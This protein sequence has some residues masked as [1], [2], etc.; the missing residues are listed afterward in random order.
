MTTKLSVQ[1]RIRLINKVTKEGRSV[2]EVCKKAGISRV[3][4]YRL[5]KRY[6][7]EGTVRPKKN[8]GKRPTRRV[9]E[10]NVIKIISL[11]KKHPRWSSHQLSQHVSTGNH[12][13]WN[14]LAR[15]HLNTVKKR[16]YFSKQSRNLTFGRLRKLARGEI[17]SP[18]PTAL[19][20]KA[21][22]RLAMIKQIEEGQKPVAQ[23]CREFGIS[24]PVFYKWYQRYLEA[25]RGQKLV[26]MK[27][28]E[29]KIE[30]FSR[31]IPVKYE[32]AVLQAVVRHPEYGIKKIMVCL[33]QIAAKPIVGYHGVQRVLERNKL[34][35]YELRKA[36]AQTQL[37]PV[38][39]IISIL[40]D[41]FAKIAYLP[42]LVRQKFII[43]G[44]LAVFSCF[45]TVVGL[46]ALGYF[47]SLLK[48]V[49]GNAKIGIILAGNA[50]VIGS[51]FFC[52]SLKYYFNLALVLSFSRHSPEEGGGLS[53]SLNGI[54]NNNR[55]GNGKGN[56][57]PG[58]LGFLKK[59]FGVDLGANE[60]GNGFKNGKKTFLGNGLRMQDG[61][62]Q[63]NMERIDLNRHPFISVQI[64]LYNEKRVA[65]RV[66]KA[67][68][69]MKYGPDWPD[70]PQFEVIVC[71]DSN[72]ET[73]KLISDLQQTY[74]KVKVVRGEDGEKISQVSAIGK[75]TLKVIHRENR[76]GFK[77][78]ALSY[79]LKHMDPQTEF[80]CVFDADFVPYPDTLIQFIKYFKAT[81]GFEEKQSFVTKNISSIPY[82]ILARN[83]PQGNTN[84][85]RDQKQAYQ[86]QEARLKNKSNI[87]CIAGYQWHVLN[88][89]ENWITRGVR[90]E[91]AGSY[92]IERPSQEILGSLKLIHGSSYCMRADVLKHFGWGSSITEDFELTLRLYEKG[93]KVVYTPYV[94]APAECV[95][96]IKR[97]VRQRM[98]WAEG[99]SFNIKKM[100]WLLIKSPGMNLMEKTELL[101][102]T[103]YYL[104]AFLFLVGTFSWLLA[105]T[106]F[107]AHL[108]FW[109]SLWG[110]SLILT[111]FFSLPLLNAVGLFL[112]EAEEKDYSGLI[113]F[114]IL[115]YILV[116]FQAY[117]SV[118]GFLEKEEGPWF[119]TPKTGK[120]TDI[121][122]RGQFYRWIAGILPRREPAL[123]GVMG[124]GLVPAYAYQQNP[125][126]VRQTATGWFNNFRVQPK[127]LR[128]VSKMALSL[129]LAFSVTLLSLSQGVREVQASPWNNLYLHEDNGV[130]STL[131]TMTTS[132]GTTGQQQIVISA[133]NTGPF[134]WYSNSLP[135]GTLD[136]STTAGNWNF[137]WE[138][139]F[140]AAAGGAKVVLNIVISLVD[141]SDCSSSADNLYSGTYQFSSN[142]PITITTAV[143]ARTIT[144]A[145]PKRVRWQTSW[146][147]TNKAGSTMSIKYNDT[148][149]SGFD[150]NLQPA[151]L[152]IP[153][154][155]V[156]LLVVAPF[157]PILAS[158]LKKKREKGQTLDRV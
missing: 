144:T 24:R 128:W 21:S 66:I 131:D 32:K 61:G 132:V 117:A 67:C 155:L 29:R 75:P 127:R 96:T 87:A 43:L 122:K 18:K 133:S 2:S 104:Q 93:F 103:P 147:S 1:Q 134:N 106:V 152:T 74:G 84:L 5:L 41:S 145:A 86:T 157:I 126:L 26:A 120:I 136:A 150:S 76:E 89:S 39:R 110:W 10:E 28:K 101:Y 55:A 30:R 151:T 68:M 36:Y 119:R 73:S 108:P 137:H 123:Q 17:K 25:P 83:N 156:L 149:V 47:G 59:V 40:E 53:L 58:F 113:S 141:A 102:Y 153:E 77:G 16:E 118:K 78:K 31:Q 82:D 139:V 56:G 88:K 50:L 7:E 22:R 115:S 146:S 80:V 99:H 130:C 27:D 85:T 109:T 52:Y 94:Q 11:V 19:K 65:K 69:A 111:N 33:P 51:I 129:L 64:P 12:G 98:R 154:R 15:L 116:P 72:D 13:V 105:E 125:Y 90:S 6:Q 48:Q 81:G 92:V 143:P 37:T 54:V 142:G 107:K 23:A 44:S 38:I 49:P 14:V 148:V 112:E 91:Y 63:I 62:L 114:I 138:G 158:W 42:L 3:L 20:L 46:G 4:F 124:S 35:T 9:S 79:A 45:L 71:D 34:N 135:T 8:K 140:Y 97:L 121:F 57:K 60:G 70:K 95:S 100:F